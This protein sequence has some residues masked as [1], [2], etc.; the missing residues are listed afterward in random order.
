M[1]AFWSR[2]L[3]AAAGIPLVLWLVYLGGWPMF[4]LAAVGA[5]IALHELYWMTRTLRP[6]VL[7]GYLGALAVL[8]GAT[9]GG[10]DWALAGLLSTLLFAFVIKGGLSTVSVSVTVLG[11]VWIGLGLAHALLLRDIDEHGVLAVYTVLLAVWAGDAAAY[12]VGRLVGRHKLAPT[13][14]PG[15]SWEGLIAGTVATVAVTF[16]AVYEQSFLTISESLVLGV[17]IAIVAPLGDLFE[18]ALKRDADVKD[19]GRLLAGH[20]GVLDRID[21]LLF[22][23][24]AA[25]YVVVAFGA[26]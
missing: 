4:G 10:A 13:V 21:A 23:W 26:A 25:Y 7:A 18:S 11:V 2:I 1:S 12:F 5:L 22:A 16:V 9:L 6:V 17:V 14:S 8:L 24:V 20:G 3:I 15:K 19:S